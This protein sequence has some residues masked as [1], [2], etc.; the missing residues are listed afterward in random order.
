MIDLTV[1]LSKEVKYK[2]I[3]DAIEK[4]AIGPLK[5]ILSFIDDNNVST[6]FIGNTHSSNFDAHAS[7]LLKNNF[8][9]LVSWY[10]NVYGYSHRVVD[11]IRYMAKKD[12]EQ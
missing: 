8:V 7:I 11:L 5:G 12:H 10:D 1:R 3:C 9:K 6:D 2:E 4:A